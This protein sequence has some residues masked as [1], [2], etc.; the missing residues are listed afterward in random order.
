MSTSAARWVRLKRPSAE[1]VRRAPAAAATAAPP[2]RPISRTRPTERRHPDRSSALA[3][4][5]TA[6]MSRLPSPHGRLTGGGDGGVALAVL[7][8]PVPHADDAAGGVGD[9]LV[10]G[11]EQNGL[12]ARVQAAE[13]LEHLEPAGR[14]E[15]AGG[16]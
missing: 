16:L 8:A 6:G 7:D 15:G 12:A 3:R 2:T 13:E 1:S 5:Q 10:V 4:A 14:V 11:D 9:L